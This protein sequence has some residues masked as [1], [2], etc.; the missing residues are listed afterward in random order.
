MRAFLDAGDM[1]KI[2]NMAIGFAIL[3]TALVIIGSFT[4][5]M[6]DEKNRGKLFMLAVS[7]PAM[8]TT[9]SGGSHPPL[10]LMNPPIF[11]RLEKA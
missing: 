6:F 7:A 9:V 11:E 1:V 10:D 2:S 3:G 5:F 4:A 8:I